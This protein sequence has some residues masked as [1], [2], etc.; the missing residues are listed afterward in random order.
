M[1]Q[2]RH[3][4]ARMPAA[5]VGIRVV[6][7]KLIFLARRLKKHP[8]WGMMLSATPYVAA[9]IA[10]AVASSQIVPINMGVEQLGAYGRAVRVI[11]KSTFVVP[12]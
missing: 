9:C 5:L 7:R 12:R 2:K 8:A 6:H 4:H 1:T 10:I 3:D 11:E